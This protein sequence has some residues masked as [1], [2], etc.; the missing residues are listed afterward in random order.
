MK[1]LLT[2]VLLLLASIILYS[3]TRDLDILFDQTRYQLF[4]D[5]SFEVQKIAGNV[6]P[7]VSTD[8]IFVLE[9]RDGINTLT[10]PALKFI[11]TNPVQVYFDGRLEGEF[12]AYVI[13]TY[14]N[15]N[16]V[17]LGIETEY[18]FFRKY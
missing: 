4:I 6:T 8:Q 17:F 11:L 2:L 1:Q 15:I 10:S 12:P 14:T 16:L 13:Y 7:L 18:V 5:R 9:T 3:Q